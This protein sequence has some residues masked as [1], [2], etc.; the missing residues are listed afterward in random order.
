MPNATVTEAIDL[1]ASGRDLT[2]EQAE[3]VLREIMSGAV[4]EAQTAAFLIALRTK[5]ETVEELTG[6]ATTMREFATRVEVEGDDLLDALGAPLRQ[7][8]SQQT[9]AAVADQR[10][11][12]DRT[13]L[14]L[15]VAQVLDDR[16]RPDSAHRRRHGPA[17]ACRPDDCVRR[18]RSPRLRRRRPRTV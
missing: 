17:A 2:S 4:D 10:F 13:V 18:R 6:L 7:H 14:G 15:P 5:G 12:N 1:V 8:L 9:S 3:R 11:G 16:A